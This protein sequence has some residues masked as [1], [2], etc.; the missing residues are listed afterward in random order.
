MFLFD[1][2][3]GGGPDFPDPKSP[4]R[5]VNCSRTYDDPH[6]SCKA[7]VHPG[8][9]AVAPWVPTHRVRQQPKNPLAGYQ[10]PSDDLM[11]PVLGIDHGFSASRSAYVLGRVDNNGNVGIVDSGILPNPHPKLWPCDECGELPQLVKGTAMA[12]FSYYCDSRGCDERFTGW[13]NPLAHAVAEWNRRYGRVP[14]PKRSTFMGRNIE[15]TDPGPNPHGLAL[16]AC[17]E[18]PR[19]VAY[20]RGDRWYWHA[21][22]ECGLATGGLASWG[23]SARGWNAGSRRKIDHPETM[24][25]RR[26]DLPTSLTLGCAELPEEYRDEMCDCKPEKHESHKKG[27]PVCKHYV[28]S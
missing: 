18:I 17:G 2:S 5:C 13:R 14:E 24:T 23:G 16:C 20:T 15:P 19:P 10:S 28:W 6:P 11:E 12:G 3:P 26:Y 7:D 27:D 8:N 22:C 4:P 25:E 9:A 21:V 1:N